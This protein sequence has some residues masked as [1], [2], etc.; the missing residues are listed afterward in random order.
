V[1]FDTYHRD[2]QPSA[3]RA[4]ADGQAPVVLAA[5]ATGHVVLLSATEIEACAG[6]VDRFVEAMER[7]ATDLG[8]TWATT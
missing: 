1:R 3:V 5:T 2:D 4:T 7:A 6:S 8:L